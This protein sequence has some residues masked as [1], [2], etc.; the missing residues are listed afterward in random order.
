MASSQK[1]QQSLA[2]MAVKNPMFQ[3]AAKKA[4]FETISGEDDDEDEE[5]QSGKASQNTQQVDGSVMNVS[6]E[7]LAQIKKWARILKFFMIG[8]ATGLIIVSWYN[9]LGSS[10]TFAT[11]FLAVYLFIFALLLCCFELAFRQ[12]ALI[13]VQNFG[14]MYTVLGR[15]LFLSFVA[16]LSFQISTIGKVMFGLLVLYGIMSMYINY[17][18][19]QYGR[20]LRT[21]HYFN[22]TK[23]ASKQGS[24]KK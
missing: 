16:I 2:S 13:I 20:Y 11:T 24:G 19:P 12:A 6:E 9:F 1:S 8:I 7:E 14:F 10:S 5:Q 18:H 22:R 15:S 4:V 23:S 17:K 3:Q 21:L